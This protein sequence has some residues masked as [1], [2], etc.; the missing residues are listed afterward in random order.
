M[1]CWPGV[2]GSS[3]RPSTVLTFPSVRPF[4]LLPALLLILLT[5][6]CSDPI[7]PDDPVRSEWLEVLAQK[8]QLKTATPDSVARV[9]QQYVDSV[10]S[11]L[12]RN[13]HHPRGRQVYD[14]LQLEHAA[15]LARSGRY[16]EA[17]LFAKSVQKRDP[18]NRIARRLLAEAEARRTVS[19]EQLA[20]LSRGMTRATII[21][22]LGEPVP[23]WKKQVAAS[24]RNSEAL[25]YKREDGGVAGVY[26][27][28]GKLFAA[29]YD[30]K[31]K[32][33]AS[34]RP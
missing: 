11:F 28:D 13:P 25:F 9:R 22:L 20:S 15:T 24:S 1:N 19:R 18:S 16:E 27:E 31:L 14:Q 6:A 29:E 7:A 3:R 26:L 21:G 10:R 34:P 33:A 32:L 4:F 2:C 23:G 8:E 5:V 17:I 30:T 12:E